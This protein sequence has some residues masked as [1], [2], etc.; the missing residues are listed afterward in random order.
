MKFTFC[1][2][3]TL[4]T[5]FGFGQNLVLN[6]GFENITNCPTA[7]DQLELA[8]E[9]SVI[10]GTPDLFACTSE[11]AGSP[12]NC[13][14]N[15]IAYEGDN[16]AGFV[17]R[18]WDVTYTEVLSMKLSENLIQG[19]SYK[20]SFKVSLSET[21]IGGSGGIAVD[22]DG[23]ISNA[24]GTYMR[25]SVFISNPAIIQKNEWTEI[26]FCY[27]PTD[28]GQSHMLI[29]YHRGGESIAVEGDV[30]QCN[31]GEFIYYYIDD[32]QVEL[33]PQ[34]AP[35]MVLNDET[36]CSHH[37]LK[38]LSVQNV[39]VADSILEIYNDESRFV[40]SAV[41]S[42][43]EVFA[44]LN[45][46]EFCVY[47][48]NTCRSACSVIRKTINPVKVNRLDTKGCKNDSVRLEID[49]LVEGFEYHW[50]GPHVIGAD[51]ASSVVAVSTDD[52]LNYTLYASNDST[53]CQ[54]SLVSSY[55][56]EDSPIINL[57]DTVKSCSGSDFSLKAIHDGE[58]FD[59]FF[60]W[61]DSEGELLERSDELTYSLTESDFV[62][63]TMGN[64]SGCISTDTVLIEVGPSDLPELSDTLISVSQCGGMLQL[65]VPFLEHVNY[66]WSNLNNAVKLSENVLQVTAMEDDQYAVGL[67]TEFGCA[68]SKIFMIDLEFEVDAGTL[69]WVCA[70]QYFTLGEHLVESPD[71][72]YRWEPQENLI[73]NYGAQVSA[74]AFL[75]MEDFTLTVTDRVSGCVASDMIH[76]KVSSIESPLVA[77]GTDRTICQG[78]SVQIGSPLVGFE[79]SWSPDYNVSFI[80]NPETYVHPD[81]T[82]TYVLSRIGYNGID[83]CN[84][85]DSVTVYVLNS[86]SNEMT[87]LCKKGN[88][89]LVLGGQLL[90][91]VSYVWHPQSFTKDSTHSFIFVS[92]E[93]TT[94]YTRTKILPNCFFTDDYEVS[95]LDTSVL[96]TMPTDTILCGQRGIRIDLDDAYTYVWS[97]KNLG[98]LSDLPVFDHDI[99][100]DDILI[101]TLSNGLCSV[102]R[103]MNINIGD[104][105]YFNLPISFYAEKYRAYYSVPFG[106]NL[107]PDETI[108]WSPETGLSDPYVL[109]P[110]MEREYW[111][112]LFEEAAYH[113]VI[114]NQVSGCKFEQDVDVTLLP[115]GAFHVSP[116]SICPNQVASVQLVADN[117]DYDDIFPYNIDAF[118]ITGDSTNFISEGVNGATVKENTLP[119]FFL[120][121]KHD[122]LRNLVCKFVTPSGVEVVLF[123]GLPIQGSGRIKL[124]LDPLSSLAISD[125]SEGDSL[126][127]VQPI[128]PESLEAL[129]DDPFFSNDVKIVIYDKDFSSEGYLMNCLIMFK[130]ESREEIRFMGGTKYLPTT[131][132]LS[133]KADS[134][135]SFTHDEFP[136]S[137]PLYARQ[138]PT[139][140]EIGLIEDT[141]FTTDALVV[142]WYLEG[143]L[144]QN[145]A[146]QI[147]LDVPGNYHVINRNDYCEASSDTTEFVII[148]VKSDVDTQIQLYPRITNDIV[149]IMAREKIDQVAV[150]N[151]R[152]MAIGWVLEPKSK[153]HELHFDKLP[154]G[155]YFIQVL[156]AGKMSTYRVMVVR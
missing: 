26:S 95:V 83:L 145:D 116:D 90:P 67:T 66:S 96:E 149:R 57:P 16:Y 131:L 127:W 142:D 51:T 34:T 45:Y 129:I 60:R 10:N 138:L 73:D 22:F 74:K 31:P 94:N 23:S 132:D 12:L 120:D 63:M 85:R 64:R 38:S 32:V 41:D 65:E 36:E 115:D 29:G 70:D 75:L 125:L 11:I 55:S 5:A 58:P 54:D 146:S 18:D 71:L 119:A 118:P 153:Q 42:I 144:I 128:N 101:V 117:Y 110:K 3:L 1:F 8:S 102:S 140:P 33:V 108:I 2:F 50:S 43:Y 69:G 124:I 109:K 46:N 80:S 78:D 6:G 121:I 77:V 52:F 107:S 100:N 59:Y 104:Q 99:P 82:T 19:E 126:A 7:L 103:Q 25:S 141:I 76:I 61:Y 47:G 20:V 139:L 135:L 44:R 89:S 97:T 152:G 130:S 68:T 15:Q 49:T 27:S 98:Y 79:Y 113:I 123:D 122:N 62:V 72:E 133:I 21:S 88:D 92:P 24:M 91:D 56:L 13:V 30:S 134:V 86:E 136:V 14:G 17:L 84:N 154:Q 28:F 111:F 150:L 37:G 114:T 53:G 35:L 143:D 87:T 81:T 48:T 105:P 112:E 106:V 147:K 39:T 148:S 4:V 137:F 155:V 40:F 156:S 93:F 151:G 9:V